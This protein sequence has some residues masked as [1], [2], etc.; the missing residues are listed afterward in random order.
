[1]GQDIHSVINKGNKYHFSSS[2]WKT[3]HPVKLSGPGDIQGQ[4]YWDA[5]QLDL[6]GHVP[7]HLTVAG[8]DNL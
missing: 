8:K 5:E 7:A 4:T 1:M 6:L 2:F 3:L